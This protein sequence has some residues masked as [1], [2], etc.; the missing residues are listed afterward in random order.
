MSKKS[1]RRMKARRF[2]RAFNRGA[3]LPCKITGTRINSHS[4]GCGIG[5]AQ[6]KPLES[7]AH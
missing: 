5:R 4:Y 6:C 3:D 7:T 1:N 2:R